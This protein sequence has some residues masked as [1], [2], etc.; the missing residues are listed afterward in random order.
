MKSTNSKTTWRLLHDGLPWSRLSPR[1][2]G[3]VPNIYLISIHK[4]QER[5]AWTPK[6]QATGALPSCLCG[7]TLLLLG[8]AE[9]HC[10]S[11]GAALMQAWGRSTTLRP[12]FAIFL[13]LFPR[14]L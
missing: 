4:E 14:S 10:L 12:D 1:R 3:C 7:H 11:D 9:M 6:P 13:L 5:H 2:K 8:Q